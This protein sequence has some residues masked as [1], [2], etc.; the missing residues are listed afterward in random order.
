M[1]PVPSGGA[2]KGIGQ[3]YEMIAQSTAFERSDPFFSFLH[4]GF[5]LVREE[6]FSGLCSL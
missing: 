5:C 4:R 2:G 1:R 6:S 3:S